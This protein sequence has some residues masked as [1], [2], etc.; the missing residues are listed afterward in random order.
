MREFLKIQVY[1]KF[2][3][4]NV[5]LFADLHQNL[6]KIFKNLFMLPVKMVLVDLENV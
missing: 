1:V 2:V 4:M 6:K 5:N 3:E